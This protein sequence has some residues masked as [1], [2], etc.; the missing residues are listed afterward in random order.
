MK[1]AIMICI[2]AVVMMAPLASYAR[3][4]RV[5]VAPSFGWGWY[6][7]YWEPYPYGYYNYA[8]MTGAVKFDTD[9]K[10][11]EVYI[12]GAF[13]GTVRKLK[14]MNLQP[15]SYNIEVRAPGREQFEKKVYVAAGKTLHL[16]PNLHVQVQPQAQ[17]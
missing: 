14:T 15:G 10:D 7:P 13:A 3:P 16:N 6:S 8:P 1:K 11:A 12:N 17:P 5:V 2:A 4:G 9:V